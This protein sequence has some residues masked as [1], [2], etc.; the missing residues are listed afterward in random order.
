MPHFRF[1]G[2]LERFVA[3]QQRGQATALPVA[4]HE[5]LKH[6]IESLG[7]PHT[8]V[9]AAQVNGRPAPLAL[10][11]LGEHDDVDVFPAAIPAPLPSDATLPRFI[12]D[13]HLGRLA[14]HLRFAGLDT[15]HRGDWDDAA[16]AAQAREDGRAV[17]TRDRALLMHR[18]VESGCYVHATDPAAQLTRVLRRFGLHGAVLRTSR[19]V[20]C[21]EVL[22]PAPPHEARSV[23]PPRAFEH[24]ERFWRCPACRRVYWQGSHWRRMHAALESALNDAGATAPA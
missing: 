23:V 8:E 4:A 3:P 16:L 10:R 18:D 7:V 19:C 13:A 21:N 12:A 24:F 22:S 14:R 2:E 17:L 20:L 11:P 1:H 6:A 5:T 15:L 9:G